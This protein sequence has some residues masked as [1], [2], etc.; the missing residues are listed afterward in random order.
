MHELD[1]NVTTFTTAAS[2]LE[3]AREQGGAEDE[4]L[5]DALY[6]NTRKE[7]HEAEELLRVQARTVVDL[8]Q[9]QEGLSKLDTPAK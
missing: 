6:W 4:E 7:L 3:L 8:D 9:V 5:V 1:E 2:K